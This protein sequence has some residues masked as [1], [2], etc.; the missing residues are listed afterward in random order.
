MERI[1]ESHRF[2]DAVSHKIVKC[3]ELPPRVEIWLLHIANGE[4]H[5]VAK[6][7]IDTNMGCKNPGSAGRR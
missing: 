6:L 5:G 4:K 2:F 1:G 7:V 3:P